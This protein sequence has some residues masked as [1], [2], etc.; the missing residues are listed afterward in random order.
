MRILPAPDGWYTPLFPGNRKTVT[1]LHRW[2]NIKRR[3]PT[4]L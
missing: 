2:I 4:T 1:S 3:R